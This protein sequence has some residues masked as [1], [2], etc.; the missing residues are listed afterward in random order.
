MHARSISTTLHRTGVVA[1]A[2]IVP[3]PAMPL[4]MPVLL[5]ALHA[6]VPLHLERDH[7]LAVPVVLV[8]QLPVL[9]SELHVVPA[10]P[11][12]RR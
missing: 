3:V 7:R 8:P 11:V 5:L 12:S 4:V 6:A 2:V 9:Y 10:V 1:L